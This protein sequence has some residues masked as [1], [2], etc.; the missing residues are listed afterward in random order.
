MHAGARVVE[1]SHIVDRPDGDRDGESW[2]VRVLAE[3]TEHTS[4]N[5]ASDVW[6]FQREATGDAKLFCVSSSFYDKR[7]CVWNISIPNC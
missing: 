6:T 4:M 2:S 5:Y 3:F 7:V 1:V